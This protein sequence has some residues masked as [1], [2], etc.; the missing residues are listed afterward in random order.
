MMR[1][2]DKTVHLACGYRRSPGRSEAQRSGFASERTSNE[3]E[4]MLDRET[5]GRSRVKFVRTRDG[6]GFW[7]YFKRLKKGHFKWP[8]VGESSVMTM[9]SEELSI[10]LGVAKIELKLRRREVTERRV[11]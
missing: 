10:L 11:I 7:L 6:D 4:R 9:T 1:F 8:T 2:G 3:T 5:G